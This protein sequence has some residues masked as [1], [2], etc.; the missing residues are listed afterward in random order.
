[1]MISEN[2]LGLS[3]AVILTEKI[4]QKSLFKKKMEYNKNI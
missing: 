1:M 4:R 3:H 2:D